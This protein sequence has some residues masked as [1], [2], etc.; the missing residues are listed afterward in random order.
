MSCRSVVLC[1]CIVGCDQP[2]ER[3]PQ[4][5]VQSASASASVALAPSAAGY[6]PR[7]LH[8]DACREAAKTGLGRRAPVATCADAC[9][10]LGRCG[11]DGKRCVA[12]DGNDCMSSAVCLMSGLCR[13]LRGPCDEG[14][15]TCRQCRVGTAEDCQQSFACYEL[16]RCTMSP[17]IQ[18]EPWAACVV[19]ADADCRQSLSCKRHGECFANHGACVATKEDDCRRST[20]C[21]EEGKCSLRGESCVK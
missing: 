14:D 18:G 20:A 12:R 19:G 11:H 5:Q 17:P 2:E 8:A 1:L 7:C 10:K 15:G 3:A 9:E 21:D 16:G 4:K 6:K 13:V